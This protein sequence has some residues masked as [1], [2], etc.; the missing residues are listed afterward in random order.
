[1]VSFYSREFP[2]NYLWW[3]LMITSTALMTFGGIWAC[4]WR[5]LQPMAFGGSSKSDDA[6][7]SA[8]AN[9][10]LE[11]GS[12]IES[13]VSRILGRGRNA[14]G[15]GNYEMVRMRDEAPP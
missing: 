10:H 11:E 9:G 8:A 2:T 6:S 3:G 14:D 13:A 4:Q 7:A 15:G 1:V 5:E 12:K